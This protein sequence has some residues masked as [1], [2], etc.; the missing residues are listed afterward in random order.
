M[1]KG[2]ELPKAWTDI[3]SENFEMSSLSSIVDR[4]ESEA[5]T[6]TLYPKSEN[7]FRAFSACKPSEIKVVILG[8]DPY[9]GENQ[10][11]GLSFSV[12]EGISFPPSLRNIFKEL[13]EDLEI[14]IPESGNLEA[15]AKQGVFLLNACLSVEAGK[16]ASHKDWGWQ[17]FTDAVL[18]SLANNYDNIVYVLWGGFAQ[19]KKSLIDENK[20][21]IICSPHP[22]PLSSYRGFFGSKPFSRANAY[23]E[24]ENRETINWKL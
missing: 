11:H 2:F 10:A 8:Q 9:H 5:K 18:K 6:K 24:K 3:V 4:F 12:P 19:K 22:S 16:A 15:W 17:E 20:N 13:S 14:S 1:E 21:L 23:L 7:L